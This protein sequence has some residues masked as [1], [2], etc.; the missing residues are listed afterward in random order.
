MIYP[1][2]S[3][4]HPWNSWDQEFKLHPLIPKK[5]TVKRG[6]TV[7]LRRQ[8]FII[9]SNTSC[10]SIRPVAQTSPC[11]NSFV[12]I[13]CRVLIDSLGF[14][15]AAPWFIEQLWSLYKLLLLHLK[16]SLII[17]VIFSSSM[18]TSLEA[19]YHLLFKDWCHKKNCFPQ[20]TAISPTVNG[21]CNQN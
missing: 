21:K 6:K 20:A 4:I 5:I 14:T 8:T 10:G 16:L 12:W 15:I 7:P 11:G 2:E 1:V 19:I 9:M 3:A 17:L 18:E 13:Y